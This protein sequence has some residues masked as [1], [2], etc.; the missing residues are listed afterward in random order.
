[1]RIVHTDS[2]SVPFKSLTAGRCFMANGNHYLVI[3]VA[4]AA[5]H[6]KKAA[7]DLHSGIY[8]EPLGDHPVT[9]IAGEFHWQE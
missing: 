8:W 6:A 4:P 7:V 1:M 9:P 3:V 2:K 5:K